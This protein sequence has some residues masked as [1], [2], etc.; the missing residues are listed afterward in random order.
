MVKG[1]FH[2][3]FNPDIYQEFQK[4]VGKGNVRA[5]FEK[6]MNTVVATNNDDIDGIDIKLLNL[7]IE[8]LNKFI[9][10][11]KA[12]L[13]NKLRLKEQIENKE[14]IKQ[15]EL[16]KAEKDKIEKAT[17]CAHCGAIIHEKMT[18]H[19]FEIGK[20]CNSCFMSDAK[21]NIKKWNKAKEQ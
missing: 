19:D 4:I 16:L 5:E 10:K 3:V 18:S 9:Q 14:K 17:K 15:E 2:A 7:E 12:E 21:D 11:K 13:E 1:N 8:R 20:I 6:Y